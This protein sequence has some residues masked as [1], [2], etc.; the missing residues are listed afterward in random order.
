LRTGF[1]DR[2][3]LLGNITEPDICVPVVNHGA[4]VR[5]VENADVVPIQE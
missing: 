5:L 1:N 3:D 2:C 4:H